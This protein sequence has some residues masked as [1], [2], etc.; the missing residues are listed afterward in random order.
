MKHTKKLIALVLA[1]LMIAGMSTIALA[2]GNDPQITVTGTQVGMTYNLYRVFDMTI[3]G[4]AGSETYAYTVNADWVNFFNSTPG[5]NYLVDTAPATDPVAITFGGATKY[6]NINTTNAPDFATDALG[7]VRANNPTVIASKPG[8]GTEIVFDNANDGVTLGYYLVFPVNASQVI[9]GNGSICSLTNAA[10]QGS[11][12]AKGSL[13][14]VTPGPSVT[15]NVDKEP[16]DGTSVEVGSIIEWEAKLMFILDAEAL[17]LATCEQTWTDT[18][19][20]GLVL[21]T[22]ANDIQIKVGSGSYTTNF[23]T[24]G[25]TLTSTA[26]GWTLSWDAATA[27]TNTYKNQDVVIKYKTKVGP[28]LAVAATNGT[29]VVN[30][31][32]GSDPVNGTNGIP[33]QGEVYTCNIKI[34]KTNNEGAA[35]ENAKFKLYKMDNNAKVYYKYANNEVSWVSEAD[36]DVVTTNAQGEATFD[37]LKD[38]TYFLEETEAPAGYNQLAG[39]VQVD[40]TGNTTV[41]PN[42]GQVI[43]AS[44]VNNKGG[45][46]PGT[47]GIGTTIFYVLGGV[48]LVGAAVVL[49]TR[50]RMN[51]EN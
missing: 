43:D 33:I 3:G 21:Q 17:Q 20:T 37:G 10:P 7:Y 46:L 24:Y 18:M 16:I 15:P 49:V 28:E 25:M 11:I 23:S 31:I 38:G 48:L 26:A 6:V 19:P 39:P 45:T 34:Q 5:S 22:G 14:P 40:V 2:S 42:V 30:E 12:A 9:S 8:N 27:P 41:T 4:S 44:I 29:A 32:V 1:A 50:R 35:L 47:G 36:A 51:S 13:G